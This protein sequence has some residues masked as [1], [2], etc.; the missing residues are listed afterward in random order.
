MNP[1]PS[2]VSGLAASLIGLASFLLVAA[3]P[4]LPAL[5]QIGGIPAFNVSEGD[6]GST[7]SRHCRSSL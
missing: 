3:M 6:G 2:F 7:Y 1:M 4:A 5:A